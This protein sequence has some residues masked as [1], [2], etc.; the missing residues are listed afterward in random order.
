MEQEKVTLQEKNSLL[1]GE[2]NDANLE[3]E[4]LK[5]ETMTQAEQDRNTIGDLGA[6]VK[7]LRAKFEE[8]V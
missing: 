3:Y 1:I 6:E 7:N 4:R 8:T 2:L 5:R